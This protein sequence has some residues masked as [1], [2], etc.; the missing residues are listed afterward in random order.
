[1]LARVRR[2]RARC[3]TPPSRSFPAESRGEGGKRRGIWV[4]RLAVPKPKQFRTAKERRPHHQ[5][6]L[7]YEA[8][9][10]PFS[11]SH[12]YRNDSRVLHNLWDPKITP[13]PPPQARPRS[14]AA[15][16]ARTAG[17]LGPVKDGGEGGLS[18]CNT[19]ELQPLR[20]HPPN[21]PTH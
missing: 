1:M 10:P 15:P 2:A 11:S 14:P 5:S 4:S 19:R 21:S 7:V 8:P 3:R 17:A 18:L 20:K 9:P 13:L 12:P 6:C 16:S